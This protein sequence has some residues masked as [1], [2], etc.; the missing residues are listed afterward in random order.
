MRAPR[1]SLEPVPAKYGTVPTGWTPV[2]KVHPVQNINESVGVVHEQRRRTDCLAIDTSLLENMRH[3]RIARIVPRVA[4]D[5]TA[6][7]R[8]RQKPA[9]TLAA[10]EQRINEQLGVVSHELRNSLGALRMG[11]YR[12]ETQRRVPSEVAKARAVVENQV[13]QMSRLIDDLM[14][15]SLT[16]SGV[17]RLQ[18]ECIDL[19][20]VVT[21]AIAGFEPEIARRR[22]RLSVNQPGTPIWL[23]ADA[24]RLQQV[25]MNLLANAAKFTADGGELRLTVERDATSVTVC[26]AD[27]GIG[28]ASHELPHVFDP[29][30]QVGSPHAGMGIGLTVV[31]SLV[32]LHGGHATVTSGG[33]GKGSEFKFQLPAP[34]WFGPAAIR[35]DH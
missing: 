1:V 25:L 21:S 19:G 29:F 8:P 9:E 35:S 10:A 26:V 28:I 7:T 17:L 32:E 5:G 30:L 33:L 18:C 14:Q 4:R 22:Q 24:G 13:E 34:S 11:L 2:R 6:R 16:R 15:I 31:R 23:N 20:A 27:T 3:V 12:M